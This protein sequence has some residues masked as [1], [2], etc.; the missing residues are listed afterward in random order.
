MWMSHCKMFWNI[1][2]NPS[3]K[4]TF[5]SIPAL[6]R[7]NGV[8]VCL[9]HL[10]F[11][12]AMKGRWSAANVPQL[13]T[14]I[15]FSPLNLYTVIKRNL[16]A[17]YTSSYICMEWLNSLR[18]H[19]LVVQSHWG[20]QF[21]KFACVH[22]Q[23]NHEWQWREG[24]GQKNHM[25]AK[26]VCDLY[27]PGRLLA[28]LHYEIQMIK[29]TQFPPGCVPWT[30]KVFSQ[31]KKIGILD[32]KVWKNWER[33]HFVSGMNILHHAEKTFV[34][35]LRTKQSIR[36]IFKNP[37]D[38]LFTS[39]QKLKAQRLHWPCCIFLSIKLSIEQVSSIDAVTSF[40]L[41]LTLERI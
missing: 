36:N 32:S 8:A 16:A 28:W 6:H 29:M 12:L 2:K 40:F 18:W 7:H 5:N 38:W 23:I 4:E 17:K 39:L 15:H 27:V 31:K 20:G 26:M 35:F 14:T 9:A 13:W 24:C 37:C 21:G 30:K 25:G 22:K 33:Y 10:L 11:L 3:L 41:H 19:P 34:L 1:V